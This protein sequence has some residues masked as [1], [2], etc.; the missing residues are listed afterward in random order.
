MGRR[1][2]ADVRA[3]MVQEGDTVQLRMGPGRQAHCA[4]PIGT[5]LS[6]VEG[7]NPPMDRAQVEW[8]AE[9]WDVQMHVRFMLIR[10]EQ[11]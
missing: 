9:G 6:I 1:D 3:R 7:D 5:V 11:A 10:A 8:H 4:S 2:P